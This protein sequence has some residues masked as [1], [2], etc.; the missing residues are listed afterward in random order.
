MIFLLYNDA[1]SNIHPVKTIL[2]VLNS[3]LFQGL[4][5]CPTYCLVMLG[6]YSATASSWPQGHGGK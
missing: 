3:D 2:P 1:K 5:I 4:V 6:S